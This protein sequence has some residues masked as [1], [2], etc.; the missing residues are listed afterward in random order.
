VTTLPGPAQQP[1]AP[2]AGQPT[3]TPTDQQR[4]DRIVNAFSHALEQATE[5][6][7]SY[8]DPTPVPA[9]GTAPPVPQPGRPPMSQKAVDLNTTMLSAGV[10]SVL[11]GGA[12]SLVLWASG[13]ADPTVVSLIVAIPPACAVPIL[14]IASVLK[15]A[16]QVVEAAPPVIH[17]TYTGTVHQDQRR[18]ENK[19]SGVWVKNTNELPR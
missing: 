2:Q 5:T 19:N 12:A 10:T 17:Q 11:L 18:V 8:K 15:R 16:K 13:H 7:T 4:I 6:P 14:A 3:L 9:I 1:H